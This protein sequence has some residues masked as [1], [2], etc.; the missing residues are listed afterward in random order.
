V[1]SSA[2]EV[3]LAAIVLEPLRWW[4]LPEILVLENELFAPEC[5]SE[6]LFWSELAQGDQRYYVVAFDGPRIVG[7]AGLTTGGTEAYIQS[8]GVTASH[9]RHGVG[10]RLLEALIEHA[11]ASGA[12]LIGLEVRADGPVAQRL[13]ARHGFEVVGMRKRY[14]QPSNMDAL[15]MSLEL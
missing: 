3:W 11:R 12:E 2:D 8:L 5:W 7:Y 9:R 1:T 4:H 6:E 10:A 15:I 13:Y 14:Y